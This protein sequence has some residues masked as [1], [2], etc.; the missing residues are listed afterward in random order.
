[1]SLISPEARMSPSRASQRV[2][3]GFICGTPLAKYI[4]VPRQQNMSPRILV[5]CEPQEE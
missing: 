5:K 3:F 1:M 2:V 4:R